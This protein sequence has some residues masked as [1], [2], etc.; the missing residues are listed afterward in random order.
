M[1]KREEKG[2]TLIA[3]IITIIVMLILVGVTVNIA[4]NGGLFTTAK[5]AAN[6]TQYEADYETLQ[7]GII[8]ALNKDLIISDVETLQKNLPN[9]WDI[10]KEG[11]TYTAI[12]PKGNEYKV[13]EDGE[14]LD[15]SE[16]P[17]QQEW[18]EF[19]GT[20][21]AEVESTYDNTFGYKIAIS[22]DENITLTRAKLDSDGLDY[23]II[24]RDSKVYIYALNENTLQS[25]NNMGV[26]IEKMKKWYSGSG[27]SF[28]NPTEYT[29]DCPISVSDFTGGEIYSRSY[30]ERV[31]ESFNK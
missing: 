6:K 10:T 23:I 27:G 17:A 26:K 28:S 8:G 9:G 19:Q 7:A 4:L 25:L 5:E 21:L 11:T 12:S 1:R 16:N 29:G 18:W 2:I 13:K 24:G 22:S 15:K 3:L 30:L 31:I 20:E 14:I